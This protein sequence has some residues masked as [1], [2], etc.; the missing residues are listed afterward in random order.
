MY[1]KSHANQN[2]VHSEYKVDMIFPLVTA[3]H[4]NNSYKA[5]VFR[6]ILD[7]RE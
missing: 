5:P 2:T 7:L 6:H 1:F 3:G 4:L